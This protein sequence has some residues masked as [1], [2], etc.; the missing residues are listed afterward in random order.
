MPGTRLV[1][2]PGMTIRE[3]TRRPTLG[4]FGPTTLP[5][6]PPQ[7]RSSGGRGKT[8]ELDPVPQWGSEMNA[9]G[10]AIWFI[11]SHFAGD[12]T[13]DDVAAAAGLSRYHMVRAFGSTTG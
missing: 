10:K 6:S 1:L 13:L 2:A 9:V 12:L 4:P 5:R 3:A 11:E 8:V 7:P